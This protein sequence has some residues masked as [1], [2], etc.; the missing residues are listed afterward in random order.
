MK[1]CIDIQPA[2]GQQAGIG[3]YT[4][5]LVQHLGTMAEN[6]ELQLFYFDFRKKGT[7]FHID[8]AAH[9]PVRWCPGRAALLAW[10]TIHWPP[11]NLFAGNVDLFHFPNYILPPLS[12]GKSVVSIHD[13][14][15]MIYPEYSDTRNRKYLTA[16]IKNTVA[17]A[18]AIITG[19]K[20]SGD[21]MSEL[22][23]INPDRIF[24]VYHGISD[25]FSPSDETTVE[26]V[27]KELN[28]GKPYILTVGTLEPRKNTVFLIDLFEKLTDFDGCL[29][30]AGMPGWKYDPILDKMKNSSRAEDIHY[31]KYVTDTQLPALY[32]GADLFIFPS[33]YEGFGFPPLESMACGTPVISSTGGS[34][35]EVLGQGAVLLDSFDQDRWLEAARKLLFDT[36]QRSKLIENGKK[37]AAQFTWANSAENTWKVYREVGL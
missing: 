10:K 17:R 25:D 32:S 23:H 7:P 11:I 16:R 20:F 6:D 9:K 3:R 18:D 37:H 15:F 26:T 29:V 36:S 22:L 13:M 24:P 5:L 1:I 31:V 8:G 27:K 35:A 33:V 28:I 4:R 14:S 12:S 34:L 2:I 30:I 19:S 21:E